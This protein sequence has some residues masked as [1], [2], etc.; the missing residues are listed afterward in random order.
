MQDRFG[1]GHLQPSPRFLVSITTHL[2][3]LQISP[4]TKMGEFKIALAPGS[5][6]KRGSYTPTED[7]P[8]IDLHIHHV[9]FL[10]CQHIDLWHVFWPSPTNPNRCICNHREEICFPYAVPVK[11]ENGTIGYLPVDGLHPHGIILL[12]RFKVRGMEG[13]CDICLGG[14]DGKNILSQI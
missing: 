10:E 3:K 6:D 4:R 12:P 9:R 8:T 13:L 2:Q 14:V 7:P 11:G 5:D 1:I